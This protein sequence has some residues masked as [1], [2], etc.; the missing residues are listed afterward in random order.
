MEGIRRALV[1]RL[2]LIAGTAIEQAPSVG[3]LCVRVN[4]VVVREYAVS[5]RYINVCNSDV[6]SVVNMYL[7]HLK[8]YVV[9]INGG[10]YICC[11]ECYVVYNVC[12]K[13]THRLQTTQPTSGGAVT[14]DK[15][16]CANCVEP[17]RPQ[18][19]GPDLPFFGHA[20]HA[21]PLDGWRCCSQK[22]VMSRP[23]QVPGF[24]DRPRRSDCTAGQMDGEAGW[25]TTCGNIGLPPLARVMGVGRQQQPT[26]TLCNLCCCCSPFSPCSFQSGSLAS[27]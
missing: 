9:C 12:D 24:V 6:F 18:Q 19:W 20:G 3:S 4:C 26:H 27:R 2:L 14:A 1:L 8:F 25:W 13:P 15:N 17:S 23:I 5:R 22:R 10:G 21:D 11:I 7:D 16:C